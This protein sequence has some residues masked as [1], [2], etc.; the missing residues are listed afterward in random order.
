MPYR[1]EIEKGDR[2]VVAF[3]LLTGARD[4]ATAS[5]KL[6]HLDLDRQCVHQDARQVKTKFSKTFDTFFFPVGDDVREIVEQWALFLRRE[7]LWGHQDPLFPATDTAPGVG[8]QFQASGLKRAHWKTASPIRQ[9]FRNAFTAASLPYFN[10]HSVRKTLVA[11]G[12]TLCRTPEDFKAWSQ[13]LGHEEV[14]TTFTSYGAVGHQRQAEIIGNLAAIPSS[15]PADVEQLVKVF[16]R[17]LR[18]GG[19][20]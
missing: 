18:Q 7:K 6:S 20:R 19:D 1:S 14:L 16:A 12:Q 3:T 9:I 4:S 10:P 15:A 5:V 17:E 11:L 2:A 13:N 8:F